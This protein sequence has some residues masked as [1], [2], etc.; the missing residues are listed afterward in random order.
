MTENAHEATQQKPEKP[1]ADVKSAVSTNEHPTTPPIDDGS[2]RI[3]TFKIYN[4]EVPGHK[5]KMAGTK[6]K[7]GDVENH[8]GTQ[9][10]FAEPRIEWIRYYL[11][12]KHHNIL[13]DENGEPILKDVTSESMP[14]SEEKDRNKKLQ[15]IFVLKGWKKSDVKLMLQ[16][17][18]AEYMHNTDISA[19]YTGPHMGE[20]QTTLIDDK[21]STKIM[22]VTTLDIIFLIESDVLKNNLENKMFAVDGRPYLMV[23]HCEAVFERDTA[24][25][26]KY[27]EMDVDDTTNKLYPLKE[28]SSEPLRAELQRLCMIK[29]GTAA[30]R[31]PLAEA[32]LWFQG[33]ANQNRKKGVSRI[34]KLNG[35]IFYNLMLEKNNKLVKITKSGWDLI[36]FKDGMFNPED[37]NFVFVQHGGQLP[38][39]IPSSTSDIEPI[40]KYLKLEDDV[41]P[42]F[43]VDDTI[44]MY[45]PEIEQPIRQHAGPTDG[46]KTFK[47]RV[48]IA[49]VDPQESEI[50]HGFSSKET[51]KEMVRKAHAGYLLAYDNVSNISKEQNDTLARITTGVNEDDRALFTDDTSHSYKSLT[52]PVILN[53]I[54]TRGTQADVLNR[55][56]LFESNL[57]KKKDKEDLIKE[58]E[59]DKPHILAAIFDIFSKAMGYEAEM[60]KI[61]LPP[62]VRLRKYTRLGCAVSKAMGNDPEDFLNYYVATFNQRDVIAVENNPVWEPLFKYLEINGKFEGTPTELIDTLE[63][64]FKGMGKTPP[65]DF[66]LTAQNIGMEIKKIEKNFESLGVIYKNE[67]KNNRAHYIF[68]YDHFISPS[69]PITI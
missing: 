11:D 4:L 52:R 3:E 53:G 12:G 26:P 59:E 48:I 14:W 50:G 62:A 46:G 9:I 19:N 69:T 27:V 60:K 44:T 66:P 32:V 23:P 42:E 33:I 39:V 58:F 21:K 13:R 35:A 36:D 54:S 49:L 56:S 30:K 6:L 57:K 29:H 10:V 15:D 31:A 25:F 55:T 22:P 16:V 68:T 17:I 20:V 43:L 38:Q 64:M 24:G 61:K 63:V 34:Q 65:F 7:I 5:F 41:K 51:P 45:D 2:E 28:K 1:E 67:P 18:E 37:D 47:S 8:P 40:Y